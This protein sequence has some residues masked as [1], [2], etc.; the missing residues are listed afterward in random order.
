M[1]PKNLKFIICNFCSSFNIDDLNSKYPTYNQSVS[2]KLLAK[3]IG[4]VRSKKKITRVDELVKII[5]KSKKKIFQ[6]RLIQVL[7]P[8]RH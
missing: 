5:E 4:K 3:N 6:Q 8:F 7:K 2:Q 1:I